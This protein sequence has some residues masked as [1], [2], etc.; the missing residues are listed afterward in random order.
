MFW[1]SFSI[2][3]KIIVEVDQQTATKNNLTLPTFLRFEFD[4]PRGKA[5]NKQM[6]NN[7]IA[8]KIVSNFRK[9]SENNKIIRHEKLNN[10]ILFIIDFFVSKYLLIEL[11]LIELYTII[12]EQNKKIINKKLKSNFCLKIPTQYKETTQIPKCKLD[13]I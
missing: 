3:G 8:N 12:V 11:Y 1:I 9:K 7:N 4:N 10:W 5:Y 6:K 2:A 13:F